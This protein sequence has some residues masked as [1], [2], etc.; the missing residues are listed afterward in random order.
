MLTWKFLEDYFFVNLTFIIAIS[1]D[2]W[3]NRKE[4]QDI[5][6]TG[7]FPSAR[8]P[9]VFPIELQN[10]QAGQLVGQSF[11][12]PFLKVFLKVRNEWSDVAEQGPIPT[13][14]ISLERAGIFT[15]F[16]KTVRN[17]IT[18][19]NYIS[20]PQENAQIIEDFFI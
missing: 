5:Y 16:R 8:P 15:D 3:Y 17:Y 18:S 13:F 7:V 4:H 1:S 14:N 9:S 2:G 6:L 11:V 12:G 20:D 19:Q 10:L